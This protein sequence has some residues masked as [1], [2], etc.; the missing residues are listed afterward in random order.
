MRLKTMVGLAMAF[1]LTSGGFALAARDEVEFGL[2]PGFSFPMN[3]S[4][5]EYD[6]SFYLA[7]YGFYGLRENF[8]FGGEIGN[9]FGHDLDTDLLGNSQRSELSLFHLTP[10]MKIG[11]FFPVLDNVKSHLIAGFGLYITELESEVS[12]GGSSIS[13]ASDSETDL[14]FNVGLDMMVP[15][16]ALHLG[17]DVRYHQVFSQGQDYKFVIP[18]ARVSLVF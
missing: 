9:A 12:L 18:T 13:R 17:G 4:L 16:G 14:G 8:S 11:G 2:A 7:G 10:T 3:S 1:F 6:T 15:F 5:D